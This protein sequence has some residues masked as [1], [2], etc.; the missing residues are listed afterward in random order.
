MWA[1]P[2]A[3]SGRMLSQRGQGQETDMV[4]RKLSISRVNIIA[5][6]RHLALVII[7]SRF[8]FLFIEGFF[9]PL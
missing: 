4:R 7:K 1:L 9:F 8:C 2:C 5:H 3:K 6:I